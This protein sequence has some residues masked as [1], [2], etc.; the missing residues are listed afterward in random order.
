MG[1]N[2]KRIAVFSFAVG[3]EDLRIVTSDEVSARAAGRGGGGSHHAQ[4][5][6]RCSGILSSVLKVH[7]WE[8]VGSVVRIVDGEI[9]LE[10]RVSVAYAQGLRRPRGLT[11]ARAVWRMPDG[12][13]RPLFRGGSVEGCDV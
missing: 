12:H 9:T 5:R 6:L 3:D 10:I 13:H 1:L 8:G 11:F 2:N 4:V 7:E